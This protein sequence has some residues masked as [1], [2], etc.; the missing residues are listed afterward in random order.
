MATF[1][2]YLLKLGGSSGTIF[3]NDF[4][5][6]DTY[7]VTP[8][9]RL[10]LDSKRDQ[11]GVLHRTVL[12]HQATHLKFTLR[13]MN[14]AEHNVILDIIHNAMSNTDERKVVVQYWDDEWSKYKTGTFY[15]PDME[16]SIKAIEN[17]NIYY[18]ELEL[19][20]IEY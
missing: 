7:K 13:E 2:G 4:I 16:F 6:Y 8:N 14:L 12:K 11:T 17:R 1:Q 9:S 18:G 19:E 10:D 15:F 5:V 20:L 3:P